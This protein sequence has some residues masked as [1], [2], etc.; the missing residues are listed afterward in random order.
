MHLLE[1]FYD[2]IFI[3]PAVQRECKTGAAQIALQH[4]FFN[5]VPVNNILLLNMGEGEKEV[6]SLAFERDIKEILT[7]DLRPYNYALRNGLSPIN[8]FEFIVAAKEAQFI[9]KVQPVLDAMREKGEGIHEELYQ[10]I[11]RQAEEL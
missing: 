8:S 5:V 1:H 2:E 11:L 10:E 4:S 9:D 3:P 7:D 6:L